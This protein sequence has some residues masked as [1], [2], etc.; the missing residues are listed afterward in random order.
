[1]PATPRLAP[2]ATLAAALALL[3]APASAL[4]M[5]AVFEGT[6]YSSYDQSGLFGGT[7]GGNL[8]GQAFRLVYTFDTQMGFRSGAPATYDDIAGGT[9]YALPDPTLSASLTINGNTQTMQGDYASHYQVCDF[10]YCGVDQYFTNIYDYAPGAGGAFDL[11][12]VYAYFYDFA[13]FIPDSLD[14]P[15]S[16]SGLGGPAYSF[17]QFQFYSYDGLA[18]SVYTYGNLTLDSFTVAP[19]SAIPLPAG[20]GLL[21]TA[22]AGFGLIR[23]RRGSGPARDLAP[24]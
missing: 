4:T 17:G 7:P 5:Q 20:A 18:Y 8:D 15:F 14:T 11:G 16:L 24:A 12:Q 3:A 9:A 23:R 19:V 6:V 22:L 2:A 1:M 21:L 10:G 13:D